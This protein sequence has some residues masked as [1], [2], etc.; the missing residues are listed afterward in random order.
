MVEASSFF[1]MGVRQMFACGGGLSRADRV[2]KASVATSPLPL[3]QALRLTRG[4]LTCSPIDDGFGE[5]AREG[6]RKVHTVDVLHP[7]AEPDI[8]RLLG[9]PKSLK[10]A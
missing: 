2:K 7:F 6:L 5:W 4:V 8:K 10:H 3:E 9:Y 1:G